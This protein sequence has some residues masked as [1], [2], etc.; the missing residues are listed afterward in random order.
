MIRTRTHQWIPTD[1]GIQMGMQVDKSGG[2]HLALG[3]NGFRR[4]RGTQI[5]DARN[6]SVADRYVGLNGCSARAVDDTAARN[7]EIVFH[8]RPQKLA[9]VAI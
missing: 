1:L 8:V 5:T 9:V 2:N 6:T 3:I 7:N 4:R